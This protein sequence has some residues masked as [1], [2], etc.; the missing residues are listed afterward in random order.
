MSIAVF[1]GLLLVLV[2]PALGAAYSHTS[3]AASADD[4]FYG[5]DATGDEVGC[6]VA[7]AGDVDGD[8][9]GDVAVGACKDRLTLDKE[10]VVSV[11]YGG[12]QGLHFDPSWQEGSGAPGSLFGAAVA[13]AGDVNGD[14]YD[15]LLIGAPEFKWGGNK[16]GAAY[17]YFGSSVGLKHE[18]AWFTTGDEQDGQY[19]YAVA[20]AG[21]VNGDGCDDWLVGARYQSPTDDLTA[22]EGAVYLFFGCEDLA[23]LA[24]DWTYDGDR[25]HAHVGASVAAAGD[26]NADGYADFLVGAP[27]YTADFDTEGAVLLFFGGEGGPGPAPDWLVPGGQAGAKLGTSVAGAGD[28]DRDGYDDVLAGAPHLDT[29]RDDSG[30]MLLF[31]GQDPVPGS[32]PTILAGGLR[33][34]SLTGFAVAGGGD[35]DGDGYDDVLTGAYLGMND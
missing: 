2:A 23:D 35:L 27:D 13:S 16:K 11:F 30:A 32:A 29:T 17:L 12:P 25:P 19:G 4:W 15:D 20:G 22:G 1:A 18:P 28:V 8:G 14:G 34:G 10:G 7:S 33:T 26:V 21:D 3:A 9:Y 6:A 5:G 31:Y 24:P